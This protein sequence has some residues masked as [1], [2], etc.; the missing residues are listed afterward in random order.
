MKDVV[1]E[2]LQRG[3]HGRTVADKS[4]RAGSVT[5]TDRPMTRGP[6]E[7]GLDGAVR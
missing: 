4:V 5:R 1:G 3:Q 2:K 6:R 7:S